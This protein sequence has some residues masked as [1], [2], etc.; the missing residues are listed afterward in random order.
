MFGL[1]KLYVAEATRLVAFF[2]GDAGTHDISVL[3]ESLVQVLVG[4]LVS[5]AF[6][7]DVSFGLH[8]S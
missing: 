5:E 2:N 3:L 1:A 6:H 8:T 7:E 4:P